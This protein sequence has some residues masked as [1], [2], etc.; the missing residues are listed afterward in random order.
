M[1]KSKFLKK[2]LAMLLALMLVVA[3]IPLSASAETSAVPTIGVGN[4]IAKLDGTTYTVEA[5]S[6]DVVLGGNAPAGSPEGTKVF[7]IDKDGKDL[8]LSTNAEVDLTEVATV[9]DNTYTLGV[10]LRVPQEGSAAPAVTKYTLV[11]TYNEAVKGTSTA[12]KYLKDIAGMAE[13]EIGADKITIVAEFG[14]P[15]AETDLAKENFVPADPNA[16]VTYSNSSVKVVSDDGQITK[17]YEVVIDIRDGLTSFEVEG[18]I[19]ETEI[20][21]NPANSVTTV[22]L[23]VPYDTDLTKLVPTFEFGPDAEALT[24]YGDNQELTSGETE[25]DFTATNGKQLILWTDAD[26][27]EAG[28]PYPTGSWYVVNVTINV[29][30]NTNGV[31]ESIQVKSTDGNS[32]VIEVA[33]PGTVNVEMPKGYDFSAATSVTVELTG[34]KEAKVEVLGQPNASVGNGGEFDTDGEVTISGVDI[35]S[36]SFIIR[37]SSQETG[38][39]YNEYTINLSAAA[40]AGVELTNIIVKGD[41]DGDNVPETYEM[42][43]DYTVTLPYTAKAIVSKL[44]PND[45]D[46]DLRIY[47]AASTGA[48]VGC[49]GTDNTDAVPVGAS[50]TYIFNP[51]VD[52]VEKNNERDVTVSNAG[53]KETYTI[54]LAYEDGLTGHVLNSATLVGEND[55]AKI[56]TDN[57]YNTVPGTAKDKNGNTVNTLRVNVPSEYSFTSGTSV[58]TS[59]LGLS[60]GAVA[61]VVA[62]GQDTEKLSVLDGKAKGAQDVTTIPVKTNLV[63]SKGVLDTDAAT[64]IIYVVSEQ[65]YVDG[66]VANNNF[67]KVDLQKLVADKKAAAYYVYGVHAA[68]KTGADLVSIESTLDENIDVTMKAN[69]VIEIAVPYSYEK[70][71][72]NE[73]VFFTLNFRADAMATVRAN[74]ESNGYLLESDLGNPDNAEDA[75]QFNVANGKKLYADGRTGGQVNSIIVT[76]E[77]YVANESGKKNEYTIEIKVKEAETGDDLL[78]VGASGATATPD[79]NR[80]VNLTLPYGS[81]KYPVKLDIEASK[82]ATVYVGTSSKIGELKVDANLYDPEK[83]YDLNSDL[84]ILVVAENN[85]AQQVYTLK[86]TVAENFFDV[87]NDQ[88]YYDEVLK[89][90]ENKWVNGTKPGYFEP[91]GTMTRGDFALIIARI[92]NYNPALYTESAFPDVEST[93]YYSAAI[94]YCK[95]MGYLGGENGYFNPKDP[96]TREEMAKIIC[97][98]AGVD[99]VT[100]PTSPYADDDTIAEWAKGYVYGCQAAEIMMGDENANTFDARSNATRAEAAAVLVR[101]FA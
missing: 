29:A 49:G 37:V 82:L 20:D 68:P 74:N 19:G 91:N 7:F 81:T 62:D 25:H 93:D 32:N 31:L 86:T 17:N 44:D 80:D 40:K 96:I 6:T 43:E 2:S 56:T 73:D 95:E 12:I 89:A 67:Y 5:G 11:I 24:T 42:G 35:S 101:A 70:D 64:T 85:Q 18:Q 34:S 50:L 27:L 52:S 72:S 39:E 94:A 99:Q 26:A 61:F 63:D 16:T 84:K 45:N 51:S 15:I 100:D 41:V 65:V 66:Q 76:S 9:S 1:N 14:K 55:V 36:K 53:N 97:N 60:E 28:S 98:A 3:M 58:Y 92:K 69:N 75:T 4:A 79:T 59:A 21:T 83:G 10:E 47:F 33:A 71:N 77:D 54:K 22:E 13:Y 46:P 57:T 8:D 78:S 23:T 48:T 87:A 30:D 88:W 38:A 90:A